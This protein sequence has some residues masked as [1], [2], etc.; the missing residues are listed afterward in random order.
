MH[1]PTNAHDAGR[2]R[3]DRAAGP[4][5]DRECQEDQ[6]GH[7]GRQGRES[8]ADRC[9]PG[10]WAGTASFPAHAGNVGRARALA[11]TMLAAWGAPELAANAETVVSELVGNAVRHGRGP[12][13]LA[14]VLT[15]GALQISVAD[16]GAELPA[17][18]TA[19]PGDTSG[20]GLRI[21]EALCDGWQVTRRLT[22]KTVTCWL[23]AVTDV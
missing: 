20:R 13:S 6:D 21:V 19:R 10:A 11:R 18:R 14:V 16:S 23:P 12:V 7:N 22:G 3:P 9:D 8:R 5:G 17:P 4:I 2:Q 15:A 1:V